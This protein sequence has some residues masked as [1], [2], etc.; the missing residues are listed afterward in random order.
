MC[1]AFQSGKAVRKSPDGVRPGLDPTLSRWKGWS[2]AGTTCLAGGRSVG[3]AVNPGRLKAPVTADHG[4]CD[5]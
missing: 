1:H 5:A 2:I 3:R 4:D